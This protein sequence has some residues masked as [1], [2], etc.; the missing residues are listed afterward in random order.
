MQ[1]QPI[2][3]INTDKVICSYCGYEYDASY[4]ALFHT[5]EAWGETFDE[6]KGI[7]ELTKDYGECP[8]PKCNKIFQFERIVKI[9]YITEKFD[10]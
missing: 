9:S 1:Q 6:S 7:Q 3:H 10:P 2:N 4:E 8:C 5:R